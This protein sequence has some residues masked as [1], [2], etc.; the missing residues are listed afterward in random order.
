MTERIP[1]L[2][3]LNEDASRLYQLYL[4]GLS[5]K[6]RFKR[7]IYACRHIRRYAKNGPGVKESLFTYWFEIDAF[8]DLKDYKSA[9][10]QLRRLETIAVG[11]KR[12]LNLHRW[13]K[14]DASILAHDY[15]PLLFYLG[16]YRQGCRILELS[17]DFWFENE[18]VHSYEL[19]NYIYNGDVEPWH[20]C[21]VT[22][23][24]FY[25]RLGKSLRE[26]RHWEAFV[27]GL[28]PQLFQLTGKSRDQLIAD[29]SHL[30]Q[31]VS[32]LTM[33][34]QE[35]VTSGYSRGLNDL[36][37]TAEEVEKQQQ[38]QKQKIAEADLHSRPV[39]LRINRKL[40]E[41][42]PELKRRR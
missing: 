32:H 36:I 2:W 14:N 28:H 26:W 8:C 37:E 20:R 9:W 42:F 10:R 6:D 21:R 23:F 4:C 29:P 33:I 38:L 34:C 18:I 3:R 11:E 5:M 15:A 19:L 22:L 35:R 17:L 13:T 25:D 24:H 7:I 27:Q 40:R 41:L 16:R 30:D 39:R 12:N 1:D 31:F